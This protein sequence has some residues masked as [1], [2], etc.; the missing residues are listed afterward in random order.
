MTSGDTL[1]PA[2]T[3]SGVALAKSEERDVRNH[4]GDT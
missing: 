4:T 3:L 2:A 1:T